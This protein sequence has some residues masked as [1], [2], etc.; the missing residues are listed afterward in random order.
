VTRSAR[1]RG[2]RTG[3]ADLAWTYEAMVRIRLFEEA[4][5]EMW[6]RGLIS[7]ELHTSIGEEAIVAGVVA[8]LID[9][10]A[11]A[12][13]HRS[14]G[15]FVARGVEMR[16]LFLE[17]LGSEDGLC[18]GRGGHMHLFAPDVLAASDGIVGA[19]GPLACG[20]ALA[21]RHLRPG[22]VAVAF[23]GEG[24]ANQGAMMEAFN[25]A[26]TWKLPVVFVCKDNRW[27]ITTRS[28][29]V[30]GGSLIRRARAFGLAAVPVDGTRVDRT[31][32]VA[33][34]LIAR[35]RRGGGPGFILARCHRPQGHF[36]GDPML[37]MLEDPVHQ[38]REMGPPLLR[39]AVGS[40]DSRPRDRLAASL[41]L[42]LRLAAFTRQFGAR[43]PDPVARA[44]RLL[45]TDVADRIEE[46]ARRAVEEA[47]RSALSHADAAAAGLPA[48][49]PS[50]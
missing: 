39:S 44:R 30:T 7:G 41:H 34:R 19:G 3:G 26:V 21:A 50:G 20:F 46:R 14:T 13:D 38:G 15:P 4:Q 1:A 24:A 35:T 11:M 12:V 33:A 31:A 17:V 48:T 5:I 49:G 2:G 23:F 29:D 16:S 47:A 42:A 37:R 32:R 25:L 18:R 10:D 6:E 43:R 22:R 36:M 8:S 9:G 27:S 45:D 28:A 40:R